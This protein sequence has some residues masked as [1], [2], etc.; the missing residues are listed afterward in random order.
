MTLYPHVRSGSLLLAIAIASAVACGGTPK[1]QAS[2]AGNKQAAGPTCASVDTTPVTLAV[3]DYIKNA[4]PTPQRYLSAYGTDSAVPED[5]FKALLAKGPTYYWNDNPKA[6]EQVKKKLADVGPYATLLL[7]YRGKDE[8]DGG[9]TVN[10]KLGGH[11]VGGEH[12]GKPA[13]ERAIQVHC[14]STGWRLTATQTPPAAADSAA[15]LA[16]KKP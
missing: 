8:A 3:L 1:D 13:V 9:N 15:A 6:Q 4:R 12:D 7:V 5:G 11:Y 14:D 16:P 2:S 10:V